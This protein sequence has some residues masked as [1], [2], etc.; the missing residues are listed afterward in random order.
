[1]GTDGLDLAQDARAIVAHLTERGRL[2]H[3]FLPGRGGYLYII[4]GRVEVDG[5]QLRTG[6]AAKVVGAAD[7]ALRTDVAAELI[8]VDVPLRFERVG[9][10]AGES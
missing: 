10:W 2:Q 1:V 4:D 7:L 8:L 5:D 3:A 9:A 6:D